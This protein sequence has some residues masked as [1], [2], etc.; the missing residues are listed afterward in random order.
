MFVDIVTA[1]LFVAMGYAIVKATAIVVVRV[2]QVLGI[3]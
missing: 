2:G 3:I 1:V